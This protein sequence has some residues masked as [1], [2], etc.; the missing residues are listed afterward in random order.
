M[1]VFVFW[2]VVV[3]LLVTVNIPNL[4][5]DW[6]L[7]PIAALNMAMALRWQERDLKSIAEQIDFSKQ[8]SQ[9]NSEREDKVPSG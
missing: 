1:T 4:I 7:I 5:V 6:V 3:I 8:M 2:G 9:P